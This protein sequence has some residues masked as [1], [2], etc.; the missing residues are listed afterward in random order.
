MKQ[1]KQWTRV[2]GSVG[3]LALAAGVAMPGGGTGSLPVS[4][5][6]GGPSPARE[7][8]S[9]G[10]GGGSRKDDEV[11]RKG[12][13][14]MAEARGSVEDAC[15][16]LGEGKG[17]GVEAACRCQGAGRGYPTKWGGAGRSREARLRDEDSMEGDTG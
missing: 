5:R 6:A 2:L 1:W 12:A 15:R 13:L 16:G 4:G 8:G 17:P 3:V 9:E 11:E 14:A 7:G 10:E